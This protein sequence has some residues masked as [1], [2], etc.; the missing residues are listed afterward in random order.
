MGCLKIGGRMGL[1]H[2]LVK[3]R[4]GGRKERKGNKK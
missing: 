4:T 1:A 3:T 2:R